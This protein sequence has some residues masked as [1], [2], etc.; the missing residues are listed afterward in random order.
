[1]RARSTRLAGSVRDRVNTS[2][3][4]TSSG[5]IASSITRRGA[6]MGPVIKTEAPPYTS[7]RDRGNPQNRS[8]PWNRCTRQLLG[9]LDELARKW[10][11]GEQQILVFKDAVLKI[12]NHVFEP[13]DP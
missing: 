10:E 2:N 7:P 4:P 12:W 5:P 6:A 8:V 11:G 1:M 3:R 13:Q 9:R